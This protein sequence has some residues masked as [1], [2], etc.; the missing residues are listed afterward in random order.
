[1][2]LTNN[3][4]GRSTM[5]HLSHCHL[6][7][8]L[9]VFPGVLPLFTSMVL[10][11]P[12]FAILPDEVA[13]CHLCCSTAAHWGTSVSFQ[14]SHC[15]SILWLYAMQNI[16]LLITRVTLCHLRFPTVAHWVDQC[17]PSHHTPGKICGC[18]HLMYT[19]AAYWGHLSCVTYVYL[20][21]S[22]SFYVSQCCSLDWFF[23]VT[24]V[25]LPLT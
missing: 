15:S 24:C 17:R 21:C 8:W 16:P 18:D 20:G 22:A 14:V 10:P 13:S 6:M 1:M 4:C 7:W 11:H 2:W 23:I 12:R 5:F 3:H 25:W 19:T 9:W